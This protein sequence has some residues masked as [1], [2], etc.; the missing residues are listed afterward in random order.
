MRN[1]MKNF[2]AMC[3][4][5]VL[6]ITTASTV[7]AET[8]SSTSSTTAKTTTSLSGYGFTIDDTIYTK[9]CAAGKIYLR[10]TETTYGTTIITMSTRVWIL[11]EANT[12]NDVILTWTEI[13]PKTYY[14]NNNV[15]VKTAYQAYPESLKVSCNFPSTVEYCTSTPKTQTVSE[16][17]SV[18]AEVGASSDGISGGISGSMNIEVDALKIKNQSD[19]GTNL[20]QV[21]YDYQP[22]LT[23]YSTNMVDYCAVT[24]EQIGTTYVESS[25]KNYSFTMNFRLNTG[26]T[27][28]VYIYNGD[29][30]FANTLSRTISTGF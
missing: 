18:G 9:M 30:C 8:F 15:G 29:N 1:I 6:C 2:V 12:Y 4:V 21:L 24:T 14:S 27:W 11:R 25:L 5:V 23:A 28:G 16:S 17:Y 10:T 13:A 7:K 3:L 19:S 20:F 26:Y 22:G